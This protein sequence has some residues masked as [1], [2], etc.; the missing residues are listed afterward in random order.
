M[1]S[2]TSYIMNKQN[3]QQTHWFQK[4][5][6]CFYGYWSFER[7]CFVCLVVH[8]SVLLF[9]TKAIPLIFYLWVYFLYFM[10]VVLRIL[11]IYKPIL[12]ITFGAWI[13]KALN[14]RIYFVFEIFVIS[15]RKCS[16]NSRRKPRQLSRYWYLHQICA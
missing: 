10:E 6:L 8:M 4:V 9:S 14:N 5:L 1:Y 11:I 3:K 13:L 12:K 7:F 15:N 2:Y 16:T